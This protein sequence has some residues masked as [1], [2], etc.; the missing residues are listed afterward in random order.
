MTP[1]ILGG[2]YGI[3]SIRT[4]S[5]K[6]LDPSPSPGSIAQTVGC[7]SHRSKMPSGMGAQVETFVDRSSAT[8]FFT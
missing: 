7:Y 8:T 5:F 2:L 6:M 4:T 3:R 1:T